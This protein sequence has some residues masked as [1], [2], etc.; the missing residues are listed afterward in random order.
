MSPSRTPATAPAASN[1]GSAAAKPGEDV[2]AG[3]LG[4]RAQPGHQLAQRDDEVAVVALLRRRRQAVAAGARV[5]KRNS[6][7]CTGTQIGGGAARQ[8]GTSASRRHRV[9]HRARQRMRAQAGG[10]LEH[11]DRALGLQLAQAQRA[12]Q[13]RPGP[14]PTITTSYSITSRSA[15]RSCLP[16]AAASASSRCAQ[17]WRRARH[18]ASV[19]APS[20]MRRANAAGSQRQRDRT[21]M[22]PAR[23][24]KRARR[25]AARACRGSPAARPAAPARSA[26]AKAPVWKRSRPGCAL[27]GALRERRPAMPPRG[28]AAHDAQRVA[29][30][31]G[32]GCRASTNCSADAIAAGSRPAAPSSSRA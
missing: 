4:L 26:A 20:R 16:S 7:R 21:S 31:A 19:A 25:Q 18:R 2:D 10:L 11:A 5:S 28:R 12:G 24:R 1:S 27:E 30:A 32:A 22:R 13:A 9:D 15:M 29:R 6:S 14:A 8:S 23:G 3:G 17:E